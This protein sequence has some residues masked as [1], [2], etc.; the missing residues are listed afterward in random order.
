M[1][2]R[3]LEGLLLYA[4]VGLFCLFLLF[5][6]FSVWNNGIVFSWL[7]VKYFALMAAGALALVLDDAPRRKYAIALAALLSGE[8]DR[9][10]RAKRIAAA[11]A[12]VLLVR[13]MG[14]GLINLAAKTPWMAVTAYGL[15]LLAIVLPAVIM[16]R[17]QGRA[18]AWPMI[19]P[20]SP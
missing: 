16:L 17:A 15:I 4:G 2:S 6:M 18:I 10:G 3:E 20:R 1:D 12:A 14:L 5:S 13:L 7:T 9:R 19:S 8:F 11:V